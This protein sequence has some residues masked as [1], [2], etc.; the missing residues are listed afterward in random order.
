VVILAVDAYARF[1]IGNTQDAAQTASALSVS[2]VGLWVLLVRCRP[3]DRRRGLI[4]AGM[5][6]GLLGCLVVPPLRDFFDFELSS[7]DL[8]LVSLG[9]AIPGCL[10]IEIIDRIRRRRETSARP[11][12]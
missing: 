2:I 8:L 3:L 9:A 10:G 1:S 11:P 12:L 5:S 7:T 4:I 6:L